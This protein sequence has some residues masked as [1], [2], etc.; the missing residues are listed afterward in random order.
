MSTRL[1]CLK[2][3]W[4]RQKIYVSAYLL[5][6]ER[7]IMI[8]QPLFYV[9]SLYKRI[10]LSVLFEKKPLCPIFYY[11]FALLENIIHPRIEEDN[12]IEIRTQ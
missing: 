5:I 3:K 10:N 11:L 2:S 1:E 12:N 9:C 4:F 7:H 8:N 6:H